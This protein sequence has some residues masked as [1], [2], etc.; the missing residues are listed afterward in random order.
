[1]KLLN[2]LNDYAAEME[3]NEIFFARDDLTKLAFWMATGSGRDSIN[4]HKLSPIYALQ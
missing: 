4:A 1:M 2:E 3:N